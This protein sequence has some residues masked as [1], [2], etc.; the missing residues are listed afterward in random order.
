MKLKYLSLLAFLCFAQMVFA[1]RTISGVVTDSD[2]KE[3]LIGANVLIKGT[4]T[5]TITDF[6][7]K[8]SLQVPDD[9]TS[10]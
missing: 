9:A 6:D 3:S 7:G 1:Q 10:L 2:T 4:S 5:G 8:F